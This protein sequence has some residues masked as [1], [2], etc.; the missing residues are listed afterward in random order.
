MSNDKVVA[1]FGRCTMN[2]KFFDRFYEIFLKSHPSIPPMFKSTDFAK[3]KGLLRSGVS[4]M[5][6]LDKGQMVAKMA[7]DRIAASHGAKGKVNVPHSLYPYWIDSLIAAVKECDAE[8]T[9]ELE[10]EWRQVLQRGV[11]HIMSNA[12]AA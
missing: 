8:C 6:M 2:R 5:L 7:L 12:A 1:S 9:P 10:R 4:M 3:Q 11:N